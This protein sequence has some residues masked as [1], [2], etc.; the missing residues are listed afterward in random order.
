M[1]YTNGKY[2]VETMLLNGVT[3]YGVFDTTSKGMIW[4]TTDKKKA[5]QQANYYS[6][7]L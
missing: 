7:I 5:I 2:K 3:W 4:A 6:T 1:I